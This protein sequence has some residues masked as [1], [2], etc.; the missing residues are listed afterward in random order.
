MIGSLKSAL[1]LVTAVAGIALLSF[2]LAGCNTIGGI[3]KD[4]ESAGGAIEDAAED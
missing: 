3:G 1:R 4:I 2:S